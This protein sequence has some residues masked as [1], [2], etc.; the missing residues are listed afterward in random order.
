M[1]SEDRVSQVSRD[2]QTS[3]DRG[4]LQ[5]VLEALPAGALLVSPADEVLAASRSFARMFDLEGR[6]DLSRGA[7]VQ[8][9]VP[10]VR[11]WCTAG[12]TGPG[13]GEIL[14]LRPVHLHRVA[15]IPL[16]DGRVVRRQVEPLHH[17]GVYLGAL[18]FFGDVT[19]RK[20]REHD[21]ERDNVALTELA[22][23]RNAFT[24]AASHE[25]RTPLTT[26]ISFGELLTDPAFGAL[27]AEQRS[28]VDAIRRNGE[29][30]QRVISDLLFTTRMRAVGPELEIGD[31]D[32]PGMLRD[33]VLE[34]LC[35]AGPGAPP[36]VFTVLDCAPGPALRGDRHRLQHV[37]GNL[38][39][40]AAKFTPPDGRITVTARPRGGHWEIEVADTGIGIPESSREEIFSGFVRASNARTGGYP[41]TGLGLSI[42]RELVGL[43]GGT[44]TA[45]G[46]E[47][48]GAVFLIRLPF[49]GP[50]DSP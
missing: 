29:R 35:T 30:M 20:R 37:L 8:P 24:A 22:R 32:V 19:E 3:Q 1:G 44:L 17:D 33:A 12:H 16:T 36:P 50:G 27:T 49:E 25:L 46:E 31:V 6:A 38:L 41:G 26:V 10:L 18:W 42:A 47:G 9:V 13:P 5:A 2:S 34:S 21:L 15:E 48:E 45:G 23:Q 14:T 43:H 28:F 11:A 7:P 40:N 39:E 4:L